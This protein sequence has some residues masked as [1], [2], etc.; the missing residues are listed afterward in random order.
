[1]R[2]FIFIACL[3]VTI[4]APA[5]EEAFSLEAID[6]TL[7]EIELHAKQYPLRFTSQIE[8]DQ[9][10]QKLKRVL[11]L[12]DAAAVS[13]PNDPEIP[14]RNANA[15]AMGLN[16]DY[17]GCAEKAI[18]TDEHLLEIKPEN[19]TANFY[20]GAFLSGTTLFAQSIPYLEK[21]IRLGDTGAHYTLA[22]VYL[23]Q[24]DTR[25]ALPEFKAYLKVDPENSVAS[26]MVSD[27]ESGKAQFHIPNEV[28]SHDV[29]V[30][31][32]ASAAQ[33]DK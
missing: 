22:F 28:P 14:F 5:A 9:V 12:L 16:F 13:Y 21:A 30:Q 32:P 25:A 2:I 7:S 23:K 29:L 1:M 10:E 27:I 15:N 31:K 33:P 26:K 6:R 19:S 11:R 24:G 4:I 3:A 17:P 18:T 8:R 20:Y